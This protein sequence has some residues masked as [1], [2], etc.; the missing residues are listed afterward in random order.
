MNDLTGRSL[1]RCPVG[2]SRRGSKAGLYD[3]GPFRVLSG[4]V[5][6]ERDDALRIWRGC[7]W[8]LVMCLR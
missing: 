5:E 8:D 6:D 7:V 4:P 1:V 2:V 3:V